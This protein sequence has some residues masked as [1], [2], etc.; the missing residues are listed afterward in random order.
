MNDSI[1]V[2]VM[3]CFVSFCIAFMKGAFGGGLATIGIPLLSL[4]MP[5]L[6]AGALLAP[7]LVVMDAFS[8]RYWSPKTWSKPDLAILVPG[9]LVG[10]SSGAL[11]VSFLSANYVNIIIALTSLGFSLLYFAGIKRQGMIA[12]S[13]EMGFA[14]GC[15]SGCATMVANAGGPP[16][17]MYLL[18]R[19]L[20][21]NQYT[22]TASI[23]AASGNIMKLFPWLLIASPDWN[24]ASRLFLALPCIF[25]GVFLGYRL[26][27][28]LDQKK[29]FAICHLLLMLLALKM[30]WTAL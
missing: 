23:V 19:N 12:P 27:Q 14:A 5:P 9:M 6:E 22:G 8:L 28:K 24:F 11:L 25:F 21:K 29:L 20:S 18:S 13:R 15:A 26:N 7:L 4:V 1:D 16:L 17:S 3:I 2:L 10:V 30:L